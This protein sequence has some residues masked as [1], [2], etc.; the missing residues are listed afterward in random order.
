[1]PRLIFFIGALCIL[2]AGTFA[3]AQNNSETLDIVQVAA[4]TGHEGRVN[5]VAFSPVVDGRLLLASGGQDV[6][7]RLWDAAQGTQ[8][9]VY[10]RH[11]S[12]VKDV[13]FSPEA[14]NGA[15]LASSSWDYTVVLWN[16]DASGAASPAQTFG[17]YS[18]VI[19][20]V[21]FSP[22]G[23]RLA[24]G[25][26]NGTVHVVDLAARAETH[27]FELEGLQITAV[28]FSAD[29]TMLAAAAGFPANSA[30][31]W[32]L[33]ESSVEP[34]YT[35][36]GHRGS[37]TGIAFHPDGEL[38]A[39]AGDDGLVYLWLLGN[40]EPVAALQPGEWVTAI[41]FGPGTIGDQPLLAAAGFDGVIHLY[42]VSDPEAPD[43]LAAL[44]GHVGPVNDLA[45]GATAAGSWMLASA[46]DRGTI[47][48]WAPRDR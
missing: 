22:D 17:M 24:F 8:L 2:V 23:A 41:A 11:A 32:D 6:S 39:T 20:H 4:L 12:F 18:A 45:F 30:L 34:A 27:I 35:L 44:S 7:L 25:V 40:D 10:Y 37:V 29:G 36:R 19:D 26:G 43:E 42:D 47:R 15:R 13:A 28:A 9:G 38:L 5:A 48:L 16:V 31:V 14:Q 21:A 1:M 33:T 3:A 46:G